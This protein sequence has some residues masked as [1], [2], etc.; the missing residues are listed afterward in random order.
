MITSIWMVMTAMTVMLV[1][2]WFMQVAK[3]HMFK[4]G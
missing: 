2:I 4:H 1:Q 3:K